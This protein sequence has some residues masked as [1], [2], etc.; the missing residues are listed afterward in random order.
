MGPL[1]RGGKRKREVEEIGESRRLRLRLR[2]REGQKKGNAETM[3]TADSL[4]ATQGHH[5]RWA[6]TLS[7]VVVPG[8]RGGHGIATG[9]YGPAF[10]RLLK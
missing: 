3:R 6:P 9:G 7:W 10:L 1:W 8:G 2:L 5:L 4:A